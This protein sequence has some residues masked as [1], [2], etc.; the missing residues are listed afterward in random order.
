MCGPIVLPSHRLSTACTPQCGLNTTPQALLV[1]AVRAHGLAA[2]QAQHC[3][4][5]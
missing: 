4:Y 3:L 5:T 2:A 1:I